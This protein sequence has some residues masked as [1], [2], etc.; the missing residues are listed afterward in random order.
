[1]K[2]LFCA[3]LLC[4][5]PLT[6]Q[7]S[8]NV[9]EVIAGR[10]PSQETGSERDHLTGDWNGV[11]TRLLERGLHLS[12]GYTG[13]YLGNVSG[14]ISRGG[15]FTGLLELAVQLDTEKAS[16]WRGGLFH[17]SSLTPHGRDF[18]AIN[19]GTLSPVSNIEAYDGIR[20]YEAWYE[21][22][23]ADGLFSIRAG[24]VATDE[25]FAYNDSESFFIHPSFGWPAGI[26]ANIPN[27]G[28][29]YPLLGP[30]V[31][32]RVDPADW[33][34]WQTGIYD[35]DP[36]DSAAGDPTVNRRGVRWQLNS[37]QGAHAITELG[38]TL[39]PDSE[40]RALTGIYKIGA[41]LHTG[42]TPDNFRDADNRS[43]VASGLAPRLHSGTY[44][45]YFSADQTL[46]REHPGTSQG[47]NLFGRAFVAPED[48]SL[49]GLTVDSGVQYTGLLPGRDE[50]QLGFGV[51]Y[52][53]VS[54]HLR[55]MERDDRD[56][57]GVALPALSDFECALELFY[58]IQVKKWWTIQPDVQYLIHPGGST[59]IPNALVLGVRTSLV[60]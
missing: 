21:H 49:F 56:L 17:I 24:Q 36:W 37:S 10:I 51:A 33:L 14:G 54:R 12:A 46:F 45:F 18:S 15:A 44:G 2:P 19:L 47:L 26:S 16:L 34:Y 7:E 40:Q 6:A 30:G 29:A 59:T 22:R 48:R 43:F 38:Y 52:H 27:G 5:L 23:F 50:D 41:W 32:L 13:E 1:M 8:T 57:N 25:E 28:S 42:D 35:G 55:A 58:V 20:L 39:N 31:R 4:A 3:G 9:A 53:R 60:F 11:R